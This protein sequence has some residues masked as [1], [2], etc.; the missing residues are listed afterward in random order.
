MTC[1]EV[2]IDARKLAI[3]SLRSLHDGNAVKLFCFGV[4]MIGKF[5]NINDVWNN[6]N[7][8][9]SSIC[10]YQFKEAWAVIKSEYPKEILKVKENFIKPLSKEI[11]KNCWGQFF[12]HNLQFPVTAMVDIVNYVFHYHLLHTSHLSDSDRSSRQKNKSY[13]EEISNCILEVMVRRAYSLRP[14]A[15]ATIYNPEIYTCDFLCDFFNSNN[16]A[17][18][19]KRII[20]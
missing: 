5:P 10:D 15:S 18:E 1:D 17:F 19:I 2:R 20:R 8:A 9:V 11:Y 16:R 14:K 4:F 3:P 6:F 13:K 12:Q 7:N